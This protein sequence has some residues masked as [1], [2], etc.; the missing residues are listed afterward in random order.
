MGIGVIAWE[1]ER[2]ARKEDDK[3][4]KEAD[5]QAE[6]R[7]RRNQEL[8]VRAGQHCPCCMGQC[9]TTQMAKLTNAGLQ[10]IADVNEQQNAMLAS[11]MHRVQHLE[12][13]L[14]LGRPI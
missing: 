10:R 8:L 6:M 13:H 11:I 12:E 14:Q 2:Q 4:V 7:R 3:K 5:L 1:Y 9:C